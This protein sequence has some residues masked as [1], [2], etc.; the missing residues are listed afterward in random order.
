MP[1]NCQDSILAFDLYRQRKHIC[2]LT[3]DKIRA[4]PEQIEHVTDLRSYV[5]IKSV[6]RALVEK[7]YRK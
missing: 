2:A 7:L 6:G 3:V 1:V 4:H 5:M